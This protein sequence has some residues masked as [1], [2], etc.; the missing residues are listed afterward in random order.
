M[1]KQQ[2][3]ICGQWKEQQEMAKSYKHRCKECVA[4]LTRIDRKAAKQRA[5]LIKEQLEGTGYTLLTP[6]CQREDRLKV[7]T[8]AMQGILSN[9]QLVMQACDAAREE[10]INDIP[11]SIALMAIAVADTLLAKIE[12]K[13]GSDDN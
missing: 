5:E 4:R 8:A 6:A 10:G 13:G 11:T 9:D 3:E 7:A 12:E 2:C 1:S